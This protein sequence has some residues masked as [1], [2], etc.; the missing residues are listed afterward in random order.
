MLHSA[1]HLR[2]EIIAA[3]QFLIAVLEQALGLPLARGPEGKCV[4]VA[5][6]AEAR[7]TLR[8]P[9]RALGIK[10]GDVERWLG[11]DFNPQRHR[12]RHPVRQR[13]LALARMRWRKAAWLKRKGVKVNRVVVQGLAP[14]LAYGA[15]CE[16]TPDHIQK[17]L[18]AKL[19]ASRAGSGLFRS[20]TL[21]A[22]LEGDF[23]QPP[24][25]QT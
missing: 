17:F 12:K 16:G 15:A 23:I 11:V 3:L 2:K 1:K 8:E 18:A 4:F 22:S 13:R 7:A 10:E 5:S 21:D 9:M 19:R 6:T 20:A 24:W 14:S 25:S